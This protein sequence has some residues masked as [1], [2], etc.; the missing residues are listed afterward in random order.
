MLVH[1]LSLKKTLMKS[2]ETNISLFVC[3][4][5]DYKGKG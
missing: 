5:S 2:L 3:Y 4:F 1:C